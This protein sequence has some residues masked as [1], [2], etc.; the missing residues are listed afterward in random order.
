[1]NRLEQFDNLMN[2]FDQW[3]EETPER[4]GGSFKN[5]K[6]G[7]SVRELIVTP[8][9]SISVPKLKTYFAT[10]VLKIYRR[11]TRSKVSWKDIRRSLA[12]ETKKK[13][14]F[15]F[16]ELDKCFSPEE[17]K[18]AAK[19][20]RLLREYAGLTE[21]AESWKRVPVCLLERIQ[22]MFRRKLGDYWRLCGQE[23]DD[24][25]TR[26]KEYG[27][28]IILLSLHEIF[29]REYAK[30]CSRLMEEARQRRVILNEAYDGLIEAGN[31]FREADESR[32]KN[33]REQIEVR[34]QDSLKNAKWMEEFWIFQM[35]CLEHIIALE[36]EIQL[37]ML[38]EGK[39]LNE[40]ERNKEKSLWRRTEE[41]LDFMKDRFLDDYVCFNRNKVKFYRRLEADVREIF[42]G[43]MSRV[44]LPEKRAVSGAI[45]EYLE[46][47]EQGKMDG[48]QREKLWEAE[49]IIV[50]PLMESQKESDY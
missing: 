9:H 41:H 26:K 30:K 7:V 18:K 15:D 40:M 37:I 10:E 43:F 19:R 24:P 39:K 46:I 32:K 22:E 48:E 45:K 38:L 8:D 50:R 27:E 33:L 12:G 20:T 4:Y 21:N 35:S 13:Y 42:L 49:C 14:S 29:V 2:V 5:L 1:M 34:T 23:N 6:R 3:T 17:N 36:A 28:C 11:D 44:P 16:S 31:R 25:D 47:T